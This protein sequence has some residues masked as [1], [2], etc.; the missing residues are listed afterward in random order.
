[1]KVVLLTTARSQRPATLATLKAQLGLLPNDG[2]EV[3]VVSWYRPKR[4]LPV[5]TNLLVGPDLSFGRRARVLD[6]A[7]PAAPDEDLDDALGVDLDDDLGDDLGDDIG[8][9][10]AHSPDSRAIDP[11]PR[12]QLGPIYDPRRVVKALTWRANKVRLAV[13]ANPT[14][15]RVRNSTKLRKARNKVAPGLLGSQYA[16]ACLSARNVRE[17]IDGADVVVALDANTHRAA[18][19]LARQHAGPAFVVGTAAGKRSLAERSATV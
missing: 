5:Q 9:D 8:D 18:W 1:M 10:A 12:A 13:R 3:S 7:D 16:V 14:V 6:V 17:E 2:T 11:D 19:L 15:S 4:P